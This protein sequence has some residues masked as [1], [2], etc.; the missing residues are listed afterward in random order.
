MQEGIY[1]SRDTL[2]DSTDV[3]LG[4]SPREISLV[5]SEES[6]RTLPLEVLGVPVGEYFII[7]QTDLLNNFSEIDEDN[8]EGYSVSPILIKV[9]ELPLETWLTTPLANADPQ[10]FRIEITPDLAGETLQILLEGENEAASNELYLGFESVPSR[11]N[12]DYAFERPFHPNQRIIAP[13]LETGSYYLMVYGEGV[14]IQSIRLYAEIVPFALTS[15][16]SNMGGN[17]GQITSLIRGTRF[18][19]NLDIW[20]EQEDGYSI[21][22]VDYTYSNTTRAFTSFNLEGE[23]IGYYDVVAVNQS[24]DTTRLENGFQVETGS[25]GN[26][27]DLLSISCSVGSGGNRP[28]NLVNL[29]GEEIVDFQIQHPPSVRPDRVVPITF[30]YENTGNVDLPIPYRIL[31]TE[32]NVP[33]ASQADSLGLEDEILIEFSEPSGPKLVLRPRAVVY[34]TVYVRALRILTQILIYIRR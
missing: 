4:R 14:N 31:S 1:L 8:N 29:N 24:G 5:Q 11:A 17:T 27:D 3:L 22:A 7:V 6:N 12:F 20:L 26:A 21:F 30:R 28:A 9:R 32:N 19:E 23:A 16:E 2:I 10:Y 25:V 33:I 15:I 13:A 18:E 34:K